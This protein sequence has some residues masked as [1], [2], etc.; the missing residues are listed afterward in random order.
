MI[1]GQI[2]DGF[3]MGQTDFISQWLT[4]CLYIVF[5]VY[6]KT[7]QRVENLINYSFSEFIHW[8]NETKTFSGE[9]F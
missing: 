3:N 4:L 5:Y 1:Y 2:R 9:H 6:T 8:I 7:S